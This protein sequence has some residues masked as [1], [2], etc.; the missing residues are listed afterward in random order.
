[1]GMKNLCLNHWYKLYFIA[2]W[3]REYL[4]NAAADN[5]AVCRQLFEV[6]ASSATNYHVLLLTSFFL[7]WHMHG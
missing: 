2:I 4:C 7:S 3:E 6:S 5:V 1:M